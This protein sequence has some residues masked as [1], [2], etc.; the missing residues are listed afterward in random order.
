MLFN[1]LSFFVFL[2]IVLALYPRLPH[3]GQNLL[4]LAASYLFY[5]TWDYRFLGLIWLSTLIDFVAGRAIHRRREAGDLSGARRWLF[6]SLIANLGLLGLFKYFGFFVESARDALLFFGVPFATGSLAIILPVGISFYTFQTLSYSIDIYRGRM[7]PTESIID[8]GLFVAFFPQLVAGPIERAAA[9]L[10]QITTPRTVTSRDRAEGWNLIVMG[11]FRKVVVADTAA[12]WVDRVFAAPETQSSL[13]LWAGLFLYSL[14]IYC[15]FAGYS[16][17]ARGTSRLFGISLMRNFHHPYF[18][19]NISDF[20]HRWH[21]SLSTWLQDYL[22]IPLGG[23][24]RGPV[25]T[26]INLM[27]TMLLGGLWHGASWNFVIW[28]G[29]HGLY[30]AAYRPFRSRGTTQ[31]NSL[32]ELHGHS[33][34]MRHSLVGIRGALSDGI[35]AGLGGRAAVFALVTFTWLFFRSTDFTTTQVYLAGLADLTYG[36]WK[37][38]LPCTAL[39]ALVLVLDAPQAALD[40]ENFVLRLPDRTRAVV[41]AAMLLMLLFSGG[42]TEPFIYFQF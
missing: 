5:A 23:S 38:V 42:S 3:R 41:I 17:I 6:V 36:G 20:W 40:D 1:S 16:D 21:I 22:Y 30:L 33:N 24:R 11:L 37:I 35:F 14:Q 31:P 8:F 28:G 10:P 12:F 4:L 19:R 32:P 34:P 39:A 9:L 13:Q 2:A 18:A 25:R 27:L 7:R 26:Q 15:D 29:L